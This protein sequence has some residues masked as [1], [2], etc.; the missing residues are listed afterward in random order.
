MVFA[1]DERSDWVRV[2]GADYSGYYQEQLLWRHIPQSPIIIYAPQILDWSGVKISKSL[3]VCEVGYN[4]LRSQGLEYCLS[5]NK[6]QAE[7]KTLMYYS[8][9]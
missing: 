5:F 3:Y 8:R 6:F 4:Y 7:G 1:S 2:T 9:R